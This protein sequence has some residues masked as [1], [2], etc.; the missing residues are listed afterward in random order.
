MEGVDF[1]SLQKSKENKRAE[2][3]PGLGLIDFTNSLYDFA[4]TA[5]LIEQLDLVISADTAVAHLAGAM[6]KRV[7]TMIPHPPD[8][9]W[10]LRG[11]KT[12]WYPTMR[13]FRQE[14]YGEWAQVIF[15]IGE[16]LK[17]M[18]DDA[19]RVRGT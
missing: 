7:W 19:G 16:Q 8:F 15:K 11:E 2:S 18:V 17:A 9:R 12:G 5:A 3:P 14:S 13:L 6:G 10:G 1:F 4:E